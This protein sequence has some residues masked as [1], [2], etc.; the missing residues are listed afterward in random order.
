VAPR[1]TRDRVGEDAQRIQEIV[2]DLL[3]R[4]LNS[5]SM[6]LIRDFAGPLPLRIIG[7]IVGIDH[8]QEQ[9]VE[10]V[11]DENIELV[12]VPKPEVAG[13]QAHL[14]SL[15]RFEA[16]VSTAIA[17]RA[18]SPQADLLADLLAAEDTNRLTHDEVVANAGMVVVAGHETTTKLIG[19][20]FLALRGFPD[21]YARLRD[22]PRLIDRAV[23]ELLRYDPVVQTTSR[24][25]QED[26]EIGGRSIRA[27]DIV[28]MALGAA[29]RD[30]AQF[31]DPDRVDITRPPTR[32]LGFGIGTHNCLG[33]S[34]AKLEVEIALGTLLRRLP[35]DRISV[36]H[37]T[38]DPN[39]VFRGPKTISIRFSD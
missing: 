25:A 35:M 20:G 16:I 36:D 23:D 22:D 13:L 39:L 2:D 3:D 7:E 18:R 10:L 17:Q 11:G 30:G 12:G 29:H 26:I 21:Q 28:H 9:I 32:H 15:D 8:G 34:L 24:L 6:D 33:A 37:V 38:W 31:T 19:N 14:R 1:F 4:V 5:G 27:G